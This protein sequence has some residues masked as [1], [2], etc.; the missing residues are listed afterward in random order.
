M[1]SFYKVHKL[2]VNNEVETIYVFCG[3]ECDVKKITEDLFSVDKPNK[4]KVIF[5]DQ[6]IHP[7]DSI[8]NIKIKILT[9]LSKSSSGSKSSGSKSSGS[10]GSNSTPV[11]LEEMYL[12]CQKQE[13]YDSQQLYGMLIKQQGRTKQKELTSTRVDQFIKNT[14]NE[15]RGGFFVYQTNFQPI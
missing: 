11:S 2:N 15:F 7:D 14:S 6:Q 8:L 3:T 10:S 9:Q 1:S 4:P 5:C 13:Q 12:F